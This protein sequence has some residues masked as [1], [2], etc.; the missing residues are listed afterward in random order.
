MLGYLIHSPE[1]SWYHWYHH[2]I[3]EGVHKTFEPAQKSEILIRNGLR[4]GKIIMSSYILM[5]FN[6][7][8]NKLFTLINVYWHPCVLLRIFSLLSEYFLSQKPLALFHTELCRTRGTG[9]YWKESNYR[10]S[11][12][13]SSSVR[14][15]WN[16]GPCQPGEE[17][18][19][20]DLFN[21]YKSMK[22]R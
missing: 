17:D 8:K 14:K 18:A 7:T 6:P 12:N 11:I 15:G 2:I 19:S 20:G 3:E 9:T 4:K 13:S 16:S 21:M 1:T 5:H 10:L 22:R